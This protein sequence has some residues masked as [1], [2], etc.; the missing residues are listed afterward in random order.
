MKSNYFIISSVAVVVALVGNWVTSG[1]LQW[2]SLSVI[3]PHWTPTGTAIGLMWTMIYI[4]AT[5]AAV[6]A[7]NKA[8]P[9][10]RFMIAGLFV[11]NALLNIMWSAI[12]FGGQ[13]IGA[14]VIETVVLDLSVAVLIWNIA[15]ISRIAAW[16]LSPYLMWVS[17]V[18]YLNYVIW[19]LN[20]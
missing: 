2:Y 13:M 16:L 10:K 6:I 15:P 19:M 12:F 8:K 3:R 5:V 20:R 18:V 11:I 4:Y 1:R 7:Y 17:F 14:A 9:E